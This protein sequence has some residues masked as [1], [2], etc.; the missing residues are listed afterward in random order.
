MYFIL[1][2]R[3]NLQKING[4]AQLYLL[5][6]VKL[7][8]KILTWLFTQVKKYFLILDQNCPKSMINQRIRRNY[9]KGLSLGI[10]SKKKPKAT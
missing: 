3:L 9:T 4:V 8:I 1:K 2:I 10:Y 6:V 5:F 7:R